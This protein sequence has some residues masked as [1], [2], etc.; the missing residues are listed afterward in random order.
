[1]IIDDVF[2]IGRVQFGPKTDLGPRETI[3]FGFVRILKGQVLWIYDD[4]SYDLKPGSW[5]LSQPKHTE[6][7][8]WDL[9]GVTLHDHVHFK[10]SVLPEKFPERKLWPV[11]QHLDA[12]NVM[13]ALFQQTVD[14][15]RHCPEHVE[16][17]LKMS[18]QQMLYFWV[19]DCHNFEEHSWKSFTLPIQVVLDAVME[20]WKNGD[21]QPMKMDDM[22][23]CSGVSRSKFIRLFQSEF[24]DSPVQFFEKCRLQMG[25]LHL[26]ESSRS[27][28]D[29]SRLLQYCNSFHFSRNFKQYFGQSPQIFR[30]SFD[31]VSEVKSPYS[32]QKVFQ[33]L[34]STQHL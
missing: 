1:M 5:V 26:L 15:A 19:M 32:F 16:D 33:N 11:V 21:L 13:N 25:R 2:N 7:Y 27:V 24:S 6:F 20:K 3:E 14:L 31:R 22:V 18:V 12:E 10:L 30:Q 17:M 28:E 23:T 8:R 34:S 9:E 29:I 4:Q